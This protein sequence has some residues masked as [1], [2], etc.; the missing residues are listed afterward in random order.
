TGEIEFTSQSA[1]FEG[2]WL[3]AQAAL[4]E[5]NRLGLDPHAKFS[6]CSGGQRRRVLL[7]QALVHEPDILLLDE[8]TNHLDIASIQ[9]LEEFLL[10]EGKTLLFVTHDR[11]FLQR[12]ATRIVELDRGQ[13]RSWDCDYRT[14]LERREAW[15]EDEA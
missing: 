10:R 8:P 15:L 6:A 4:K 11:A 12:V 14:F 9:W 3:Q 1:D 5:I 2:A 13:L 7:A